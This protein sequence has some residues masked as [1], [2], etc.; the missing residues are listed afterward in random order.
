[1]TDR[2]KWL[3]SRRQYITASDAAAMLGENPY[4]TRA[5]LIAEKR[6]EVAEWPGNEH[7]RICL[8]LE[9]SVLRLAETRFGWKVYHNQDLIPDAECRRL[10]A[11][12]DAMMQSPWGM[13]V[14]QVKITGQIAQ[15]DCGRASKAAFA[16]GTPLHHQIQVQAEMACTGARHGVLLVLHYGGYRGLKLRSYYIPRHDCVI[17]RI[18]QESIE[19]WK[20]IEH[21]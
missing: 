14:V 12:P 13:A 20:E 3:R 10:A 5:Q 6:G 21:D 15:E 2:E 18:R 9:V 4:K 11:T 17:S 1:M 19:I 8:E 7:T 16:G